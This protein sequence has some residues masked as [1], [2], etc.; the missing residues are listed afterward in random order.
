VD[1]VRDLAALL[2]GKS[3]DGQQ[4]RRR[5]ATVQAVDVD[6]A[7]IRLGGSLADIP[8]VKFS[9]TAPG[10]GDTVWVLQDG[11]DLLI[12]TGGGTSGGSD[13]VPLYIQDG[14]P[15]SPPAKYAWFQTGLGAGSDMTLWVETGA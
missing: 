9:G 15:S 3:Q 10:V 11:P 5:L 14:A 2:A 6:T 8:A 12:L 1:A 4:L 7:T 13:G